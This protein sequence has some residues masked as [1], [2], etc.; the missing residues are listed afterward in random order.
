MMRKVNA[1]YITCKCL[2]LSEDEVTKPQLD[3][4][5]TLG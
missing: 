1:D 2:A 4:E 5:Y 3:Q